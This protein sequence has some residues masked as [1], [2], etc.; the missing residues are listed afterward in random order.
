M[1]SDVFGNLEKWEKVLKVLDELKESRELDENQ[2]GLAR[3]LRFGDNWRLIEKVLECGKEINQPEDRFLLEVFR[4]ITDRN[5][6]LDARILALDTLVCLFPRINQKADQKV[7]QAFVVRNIRNIL[8]LPDPSL[9]HEAI[10]K[11]LE[12]MTGSS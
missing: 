1:N 5:R 9:F 6:Y 4:I 8:N 10:A 7:S 3:I 11:S 12:A 2:G